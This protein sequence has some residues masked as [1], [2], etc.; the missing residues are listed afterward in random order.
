MFWTTNA[1][2][3]QRITKQRRSLQT[4]PRTITLVTRMRHTNQPLNTL[5]FARLRI[6]LHPTNN[7]ATLNLRLN[8]LIPSWKTHRVVYPPLLRRRFGVFVILH[9][10]QR[11]FKFVNW[12]AKRVV[13]WSFISS[14]ISNFP[15]HQ[16]STPTSKAYRGRPIVLLSMAVGLSVILL[17]KFVDV[18]HCGKT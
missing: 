13:R 5:R 11:R 9:R 7:E 15:S 18:I 2:T 4:Q 17:Q 10:N 14:F 12:N 3:K 8:M 16:R 1:F 6:S